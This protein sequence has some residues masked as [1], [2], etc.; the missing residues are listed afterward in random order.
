MISIA[1]PAYKMQFL[2]EAIISVLSQTYSDFELIIVNDHSPEDL[3]TVI[4]KF[5]DKRIR[6]YINEK[7]LGKKSIVYNWNKCLSLAKGEFFALLCDDDIMNP[8]FIS[9]MLE[10]S[11]KYPQ[12]DVFKSRTLLFNSIDNRIINESPLWPEYESYDEF[13]K[14][15]LMGLRH[16]TISEFFYRTSAIKSKGGY[17]IYP[18]GYYADDASILCFAKYN[19]IVSSSKVY[20][21]FRK[22]LINISTHRK[23]N[24]DKTKAALLFYEWIKTTIDEKEKYETMLNERMKF[25]IYNFFST[26]SLKDKITILFIVPNKVLDIKSIVFYM[27][28]GIFCKIRYMI[29]GKN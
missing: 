18:S 3:D 24:V 12:C 8:D 28:N 1:I 11:T 2:E 14:N 7:N 15:S 25:E 4:N 17:K 6:Y 16:H 5:N 22:S 27:F 23:Y 13:L 10:L 19:G 9:S 29:N 26:A 20:I 21:T